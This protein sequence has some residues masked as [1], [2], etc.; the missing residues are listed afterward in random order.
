MVAGEQGRLQ[1]LFCFLLTR[2]YLVRLTLP[3]LLEASFDGA[4][5]SFL[6][7]EVGLGFS[8]FFWVVLG[9]TSEWLK[10]ASFVSFYDADD[11]FLSAY[12]TRLSHLCEILGSIFIH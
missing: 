7:D 1:T 2:G 9:I 5:L 3:A 11:Y 12:L 10:S 6:A 4:A 8:A